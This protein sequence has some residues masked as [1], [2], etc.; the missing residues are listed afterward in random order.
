VIGVN[1]LHRSMAVE[2]EPDMVVPA[3]ILRAAEPVE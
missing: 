1:L 3:R 2:L